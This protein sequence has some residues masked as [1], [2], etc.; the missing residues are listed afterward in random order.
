MYNKAQ[1]QGEDKS[2]AILGLAVSN[3][4]LFI[5]FF[6]LQILLEALIK[7]TGFCLKE[8]QGYNSGLTA[9][10]TAIR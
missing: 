6:S 2:S 10:V 3:G 7:I 4:F 1:G 8:G 9:L 5:L